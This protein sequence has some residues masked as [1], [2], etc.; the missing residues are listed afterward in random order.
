MDL[1]PTPEE[2]AALPDLLRSGDHNARRAALRLLRWIE[3]PSEEVILPLV[4]L[5]EVDDL[6]QRM[7]AAATLERIG[8]T[9][10]PVLAGALATAGPDT[11]KA[12]IVILGR[13]G[14]DA[15][16]AIPDLL[17]YAED[18]WL[19]TW[20]SEALARIQTQPAE[21]T[22]D[23]DRIWW[24]VLFGLL[25]L[26]LAGLVASV[27]YWAVEWTFTFKSAVTAG[28][29]LGGLSAGMVPVLGVRS[30]SIRRMIVMSVIFGFCGTIAGLLLGG[31]YAG[32]I[33]PVVRV[34]RR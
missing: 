26:G 7:E 34:L 21:M 16:A 13:I 4:G 31:I 29:I 8:E 15:A 11:R 3:Q 19:G 20:V 32:M 18:E 23:E 24:L 22:S 25:I 28:I 5:L 14:P 30:W 27:S 33:E 10:V 12:L 17:Q 1:T 6:G 9:S 2:L